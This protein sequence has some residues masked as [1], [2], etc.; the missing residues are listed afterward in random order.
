MAAGVPAITEAE[1]EVMRV[2]WDAAEA[3]GAGLT[4]GEVARRVSEARPDWAPRTV[5]T[6]LGRL[7]R[8]G[9][10]AVRT[11]GASAAG[12]E[13]RRHLYRAAASREACRRQESRSFLSRIFDG[14][15]APAVM[16]LLRE[17]KLSAQE[18]AELRQV[19]EEQAAKATSQR[20]GRRG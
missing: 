6:L 18:I 20:R 4:A 16:Q 8:K 7:V 12:G 15:A 1:W 19:L 5:K 14:A 3:P 10:V 11:E 13:A 9:A 2:L 17:T